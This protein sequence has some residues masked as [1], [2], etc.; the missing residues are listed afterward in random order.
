MS[1]ETHLKDFYDNNYHKNRHTSLLQDEEYFW[2][3]AQASYRLN[4]KHI[5]PEAK[6]LE[7]GCGIGQNIAFIPNASGFDISQEARKACKQ[8]QIPV[9]D[10]LGDIPPAVFDIVLCRHA[11]EHVP[12]PLE[13]LQKI[14]KFLKPGGRPILILP[15]EKH[16]IPPSFH[17]DLNQHLYCWNFRAINNLLS[18]SGYLVESNFYQFVVGYRKLLPIK[19]LFGFNIYYFVTLLAG[20]I[21]RVGELVVHARKEGDA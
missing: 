19:R 11:L 18:L 1:R 3:R 14:R 5:P 7:F 16:Y 12:L 15:K 6:V 8:R 13:T 4:L 17:P 2:A 20:K 9:F 10:D 21:F